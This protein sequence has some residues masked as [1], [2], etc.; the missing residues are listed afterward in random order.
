[1]N[2]GI[3]FMIMKKSPTHV[4]QN[5]KIYKILLKPSATCK[6]TAIAITAAIPI[7]L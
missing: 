1:M 4:Q 2:P 5:A 7:K 6:I 3:G